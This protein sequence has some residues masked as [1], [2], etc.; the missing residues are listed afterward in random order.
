[1]TPSSPP[2]TYSEF[3]IL[4]IDIINLAIPL[5]FGLVFAY[6]IWRMI[7]AWVLHPGD[8]MKRDEGKRYLSAAIIVFVVMVSA[9][10][11]VNL[12][13]QSLFG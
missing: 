4:I 3:V 6:F 11:I 7:E 2:G 10:G 1:M 8:K 5:M 13:K 12:I 9:W